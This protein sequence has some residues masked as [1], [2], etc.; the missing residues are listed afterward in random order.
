MINDKGLNKPCL[1][2]RKEPK[3]ENKQ[4]KH[5]FVYSMGRKMTN[6]FSIY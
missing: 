6:G 3:I 5:L 4:E 1:K 2:N